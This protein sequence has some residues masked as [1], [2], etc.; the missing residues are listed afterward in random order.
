MSEKNTPCDEKEP[1]PQLDEEALRR[2]AH[3]T[4][5]EVKDDPTLLYFSGD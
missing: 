3:P 4:L 5:Q 2:L 1:Y